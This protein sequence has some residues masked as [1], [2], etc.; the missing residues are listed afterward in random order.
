MVP[1]LAGT[2]PWRGAGRLASP[3][4]NFAATM[5][6]LHRLLLEQRHAQ[7][8]AEHL[9]QFVRRAVLG[10][11]HGIVDR[12]PVLRAAADKDAPCRP[13]SGRAGRSRPR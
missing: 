2:S 12:L 11:G 5:A 10:M 8:L 9:F 13:G 7:R 1:T 4:V 3:G 6:M